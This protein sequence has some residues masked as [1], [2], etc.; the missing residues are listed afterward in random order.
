MVRLQQSHQVLGGRLVQNDQYANN[1]GLAW[2]GG[3]RAQR[4]LCGQT[5]IPSQL[6]RVCRLRWYHSRTEHRVDPR[7]DTNR[8]LTCYSISSLTLSISRCMAFPPLAARHFQQ[9]SH[10]FLSSCSTDTSGFANIIFTTMCPTVPP[11]LLS[12][13]FFFPLYASSMRAGQWITTCICIDLFVLQVI[14]N[15]SSNRRLFCFCCTRSKHQE[16]CVLMFIITFT[17]LLKCCD[18][19]YI[20]SDFHTYF[21]STSDSELAPTS[22]LIL[23]HITDISHQTITIVQINQPTNQTGILINVQLSSKLV[24]CVSKLTYYVVTVH[25]NV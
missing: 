12:F 9:S 23:L 6:G 13:P 24:V 7:F 10:D 16:R 21:H 17:Q 8:E 19:S 18:I 20:N 1:G 14:T 22:F 11:Y 5:R 3:R 15:I 4:R 2:A 25:A